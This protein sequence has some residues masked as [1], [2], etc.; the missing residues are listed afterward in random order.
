MLNRSDYQEDFKESYKN[1]KIY[2]PNNNISR[3]L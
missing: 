2:L 3:V 1:F